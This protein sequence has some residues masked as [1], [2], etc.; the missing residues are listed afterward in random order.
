MTERNTHVLVV[1]DE[2]HL[3]AAVHRILENEGYDVAS[4]TDGE[5]AVQLARE[6]EP[7]VILLDLMM[8]GMD[9]REVRR[10][11]REV[12]DRARV[13]YF[14]AKAEPAGSMNLQQLR[15]EADGLIAKPASTRTILSK[16]SKVMEMDRP[17]DERLVEKN[18]EQ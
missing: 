8:P 11:I 1:D 16:V 3:C 2:P 14:T 5:T 18:A 10:R 15:G 4:T 7:D 17:D 12:T 9:G 13:I 6:N